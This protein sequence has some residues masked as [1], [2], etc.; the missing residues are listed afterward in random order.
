MKSTAG[1]A[2]TTLRTIGA[3]E[4]G[5]SAAGLVKAGAPHYLLEVALG[6][7]AA[8]LGIERS[9]SGFRRQTVTMQ[10]PFA[11]F[12]HRSILSLSIDIIDRP[13]GK[14]LRAAT[15]EAIACRPD[16]HTDLPSLTDA[17][18]AQLIP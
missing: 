2:L 11:W 7:R 8:T 16:W 18:V 10:H 9:V 6:S 3:D 4:T 13:S 1:V 15:A 14:L 5:L 12:C 17:A